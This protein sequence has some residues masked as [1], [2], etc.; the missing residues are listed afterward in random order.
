[1]RTNGLSSFWTRTLSLFYEERLCKSQ[2]TKL[3]RKRF[4]HLGKWSNSFL[5]QDEELIL[6]EFLKDWPN[7]R[8]GFYT[9]TWNT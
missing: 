6:I 7:Q 2:T 5:K 1:M 4:K 8:E 9:F 3:R